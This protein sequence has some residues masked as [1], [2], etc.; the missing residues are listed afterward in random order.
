MNIADALMNIYR[1]S[2]ASSN[3]RFIAEFS[4]EAII[5]LRLALLL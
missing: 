2:A 5:G 4:S 1:I 3:Q